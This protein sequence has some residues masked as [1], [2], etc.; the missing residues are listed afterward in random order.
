MLVT[1]PCS[2]P[3]SSS[4]TARTFGEGGV[5]HPRRCASAALGCQSP[6]ALT[7]RMP[8]QQTRRRH[9]LCTADAVTDC[10]CRCCCTCTAGQVRHC[11][12]MAQRQPVAATAV[13]HTHSQATC[14]DEPEV[15]RR[16]SQARRRDWRQPLQLPPSAA[17]ILVPLLRTGLAGGQPWQA[18]DRRLRE[19]RAPGQP[20][21]SLPQ[22]HMAFVTCKQSTRSSMRPSF[23]HGVGPIAHR[24][25]MAPHKR[26]ASMAHGTAITATANLRAV[27]HVQGGPTKQQHAAAGCPQHPRPQPQPAPLPQA[28]LLLRA[29]LRYLPV[30]PGWQQSACPAVPELTAPDQ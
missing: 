25:V 17:A 8:A 11:K 23:L 30:L 22:L 21:H 12:C 10:R 6:G 5:A 20:C 15:G 2:L 16:A 3:S 28:P 18:R 29:A 7:T 19:Y 1:L 9:C 4:W 13:D 27:Q 24:I 14:R 26:R